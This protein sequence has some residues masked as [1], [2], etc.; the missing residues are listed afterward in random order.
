MET[1]Q[2]KEKRKLDAVI[3]LEDEL[4]DLLKEVKEGEG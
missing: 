3:I 2:T 4:L 1:K